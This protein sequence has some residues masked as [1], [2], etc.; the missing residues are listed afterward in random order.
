[1]TVKEYV[2]KMVNNSAKYRKINVGEE[3]WNILYNLLHGYQISHDML[4]DEAT[5]DLRGYVEARE[6]EFIHHYEHIRVKS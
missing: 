5:E 3:V 6:T 1:M 4:V 2:E